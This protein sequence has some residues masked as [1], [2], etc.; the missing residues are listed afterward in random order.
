MI[1]SINSWSQRAKCANQP[2]DTIFFPI[3]TKG[4]AEGKRFCKDCPVIEPCRTY[5]IVHN[6]IGIWGGTSHTERTK[7]NPFAKKI[8]RQAYQKEGLLEYELVPDPEEDLLPDSEL[9]LDE[10]IPSDDQDPLSDPT[11]SLAS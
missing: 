8:L 4:V 3:N 5:A 6:T 9:P 11:S 2:V 7:F 1:E 10:L